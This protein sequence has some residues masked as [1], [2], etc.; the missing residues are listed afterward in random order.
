MI[1]KTTLGYLLW[2]LAGSALAQEVDTVRIM[3][4]NILKYGYDWACM[5]Q[6]VKNNYLKTV[7]NA[8]R[9]DILTVNEIEPK[10]ST[11]NGLKT[12]TL[13]YNPAMT[14]APYSNSNGSDIVNCLY[15]NANKF[16]YLSSRALKGNVR[17]IDL[18]RLYHKASTSEGDT[19]DVWFIVVHMKASPGFEADRA[20]AAKDIGN[21]LTANR[22]IVR[23]LISGDF[24]L[25]GVTEP[26]WVTLTGGSSPH[27]IDPA[28]MAT[29]GWHGP[30]FAAIHTQS[31]NDDSN[32]CAATGGM[33]D[34]FDFILNS[35]AIAAGTQDIE[36][37][38]Y[39]AYGNDG[40]SYNE[41]LDCSNTKSVSASVCQALRK[42]SDHLP[43]VMELSF[44]A[45]A[46][47]GD[48]NLP[49]KAALLGNPARTSLGVRLETAE[50]GSYRWDIINILG[51]RLAEGLEPV[52]A[53]GSTFSISLPEMAA[54]SYF[55]TLRNGEDKALMLPFVKY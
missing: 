47:G 26:A 11:I 27:F 25:Y 35:P 41:A 19:L 48:S 7:F 42:G 40:E 45:K 4:Y 5:P 49:F 33:D 54:G 38:G 15:Y 39:R 44:P 23:Y 8:Y 21:W 29:S 32:D 51:Q 6:S 53:P 17:D 1:K 31:P 24:N 12:N 28:D 2:L 55:L 3:H 14:A 52:G 50:S 22:K 18:H 43:V 13:Q 46:I 9:P 20:E 16:G 10:A 34:R 30:S 37:L 36:I